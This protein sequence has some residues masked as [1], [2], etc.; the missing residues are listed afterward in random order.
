LIKIQNLFHESLCC[1]GC[2]IYRLQWFFHSIPIGLLVIPVFIAIM[3][4]N[5]IAGEISKVYVLQRF[6]LLEIAAI[7]FSIIGLID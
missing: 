7:T 5:N 3:F 4:V 6:T 1:P 2:P